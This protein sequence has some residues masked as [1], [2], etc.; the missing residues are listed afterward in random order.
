MELAAIKQDI[1]QTIARVDELEKQ[2]KV[3]RQKLA[4]VSKKFDTF[5]EE[6]IKAAY[7]NAE[8]TR[9][10]LII[11]KN[12]E[13]ELL[14]RRSIIEIALKKS[15]QNIESAEKVMSQMS[16]ALM[17][18]E[19][20]VVTALEGAEA[21]S[22]IQLGIKILEAQENE[23][24]RIARDVHDGPA[25]HMA[26]AVMKADICKMVIER[27][28]NEGLK[29]LED[30][31]QS[32][33]RALKEV[34]DIIFD[35][36][37]MAL[38]D[39]GLNETI[40]ETVKMIMHETGIELDIKM[41]P[42]HKEIEP[43]IQVAVY[44]IIQ[45]AFNNIKKHARASHAQIKLDYGTKYLMLVIS[46][47]GIGFDVEETLINARNKGISYG[48]I[49]IED[50]VNQLRGSLKIQSEKGKGTTYTIKLPVNREVIK[51]EKKGN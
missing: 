36:R 5:T 17:Y 25:Q 16:V 49:G 23:R 44:R 45:E 33:K 47:D 4:E 30:L 38:D 35:L 14:K 10:A 22:E 42:V 29:E 32:V 11:E 21:H 34:R 9:I 2:D 43:I 24:K 19:G 3:A 39:L 51:D 40:S 46:D 7:K 15:L 18:L 41:K 50:R 26:N 6:D 12:K 48:L 31:K 28:F 8:D 37:P 1:K 13:K 27:D 20:D